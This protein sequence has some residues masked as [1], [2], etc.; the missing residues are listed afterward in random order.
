[1]ERRP[2]LGASSDTERPSSPKGAGM[3]KK[4]AIQEPKG[5]ITK[6]RLVTVASILV[7]ELCERLTYYS[8]VANMVLF[9]TS[10]LNYTSDDASVITLVFSGWYFVT[11]LLNS[12]QTL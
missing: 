7:T 5:Q 3:E 1:M 8:V 2:L 10:K 11:I 12:M 9:C 6:D 4:G